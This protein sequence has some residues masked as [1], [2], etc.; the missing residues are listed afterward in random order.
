MKPDN[1]KT[2][3]EAF[4]MLSNKVMYTLNKKEHIGD[5]WYLLEL[6]NPDPINIGKMVTASGYISG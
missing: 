4:R 5:H 3:W 1:I 6:S 2:R